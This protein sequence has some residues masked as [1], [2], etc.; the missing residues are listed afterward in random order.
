MSIDGLKYTQDI[1]RRIISLK[2]SPFIKQTIP[3]NKVSFF[4][5]EG[6]EVIPSKA[7]KSKRM[8]KHK[9]H[10]QAFTDR[11]WA[12]FAQMEFQYLND[13]EHFDL[14]GFAG[15]QEEIDVFAADE[16][17]ILIVKCISSQE[18]TRGSYNDEIQRFIDSRMDIR[19][20]SQKLI[21]GKQKIALIVAT[22]NAVL[23]E[24]SKMKLKDANIW[25]FNQDDIEYFE[26]LS[27]NLGYAAKYQLFGKL[28]NNQ[29]IPE[30]NNKVPAIKGKIASGQTFYSFSIE[31]ETL[32][33][34]GF[35]LHRT[36]TNAKTMNAYQRLIKKSRLKNI[37]RGL[38]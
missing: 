34:M 24:R 36:E 10:L 15:A 9:N 25:H 19:P 27:D 6:W 4:E 29:H 11:I 20:T 28:F 37:S 35:V 26:Q 31:P 8:R 16:E 17:A 2:K 30:L 5:Q 23:N 33:K 13:E 7:K 1:S 38:C 12:L 21:S 3:L 18:R 32:L 22:N 14:C